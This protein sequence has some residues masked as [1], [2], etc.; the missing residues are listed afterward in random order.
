MCECS[1]CICV[2]IDLHCVLY[3]YRD[4]QS[5]SIVKKTQKTTRHK[6]TA[7]NL[8][9]TPKRFKMTTKRFNVTTTKGHKMTTKINKLKTMTQ[10]WTLKRHK[11]TTV[12]KT[13]TIT[14]CLPRL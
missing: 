12:K 1:V 2:N 4:L 6:I 10:K 14:L 9:M 8:K 3:V 13:T 7:K 11:M 5:G